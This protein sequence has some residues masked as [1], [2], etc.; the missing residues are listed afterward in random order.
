M[1]ANDQV[2]ASERA[3]RFLA[4]HG[5]G[6]TGK[7]EE[8]FAAAERAVAVLLKDNLKYRER[9]RANKGD[10]PYKPDE[11]LAADNADLRAENERLAEQ[12]PPAGAV[13]LTGEDATAWPKFKA[14]GLAPDKIT[15]AIGQRDELQSKIAGRDREDV[16]RRAAEALGFK[17]S[18]LV[19]IAAAEGLHIEFKDVAEKDAD[20]KTVTTS[21]AHVRKAK[22]DKAALVPLAEFADAELADY[23]PALRTEDAAEPAGEPKQRGAKGVEYLEQRKGGGT[24]RTAP[25]HDKL[26]EAA[27]ATGDY[28]L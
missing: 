25:S 26:V 27:R 21:V 22:D 8:I 28:Q 18:V 7:P 1:A 12:V 14:L 20:G 15:E 3:K 4:G 6:P 2:T 23:L 17:S 11:Q 13:V 5:C 24:I 19:K 16:I 10:T 9:A